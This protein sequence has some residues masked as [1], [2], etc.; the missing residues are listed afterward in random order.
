MSGKSKNGKNVVLRRTE[1]LAK[2]AEKGVIKEFGEISK[3]VLT[4]LFKIATLQK[5]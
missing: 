4:E 2:E 5:K 3:G 1:K